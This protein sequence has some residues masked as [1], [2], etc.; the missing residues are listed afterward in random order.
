VAGIVDQHVDP[1][2]VGDDLGDRRVD[3]QLG[4]HVELD[5]AQ[6]DAVALRGLSHLGGILRVAAGDVTHRGIDNVPGPGERLGGQAAEATGGAGD[7]NDLLAHDEFLF[8]LSALQGGR[9]G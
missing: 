1:A 4:L 6:V 9:W 2:A 7:E 8:G 5:G 3:R